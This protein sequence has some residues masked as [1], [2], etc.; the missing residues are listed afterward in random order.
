MKHLYIGLC[1]CLRSLL[2]HR[3]ALSRQDGLQRWIYVQQDAINII[4]HVRAAVSN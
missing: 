4:A 3:V 2:E 1:A